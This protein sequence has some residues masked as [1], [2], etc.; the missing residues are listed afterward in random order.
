LLFLRLDELSG[1]ND[2]EQT[3][4]VEHTDPLT[5]E[6]HSVAPIRDSETISEFQRLLASRDAIIA[7]GHHRTK[8]SQ[9][10]YQRHQP[11]ATEAASC[12]LAVV[13]SL[14]SEGVTIDPIHRALH[15]ELE[16]EQLGGIVRA[17]PIDTAVGH[18]VEQIVARATQDD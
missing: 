2:A 11:E 4:I 5:G 16:L 15:R 13:T 9:L 1:A 7:D 8:T 10:F 6:V 18:E 3:T 17:T 14:A 12:K